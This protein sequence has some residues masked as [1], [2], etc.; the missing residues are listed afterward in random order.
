L[1]VRAGVKGWA[2]RFDCPIQPAKGKPLVT[3][4]DAAAYIFKLSDRDQRLPEWQAAAEALILVADRGGLTMLARIGM[5]QALNRH[6]PARPVAPR[7]KPVK[8]Y[9]I[10]RNA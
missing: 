7:R 5:M 1:A 2:R 6:L 9:R 8:S 3:L 10:I 4:K